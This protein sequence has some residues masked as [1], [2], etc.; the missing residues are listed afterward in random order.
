ML[1]DVLERCARGITCCW[2]SRGGLEDV[3]KNGVLE[4]FIVSLSVSHL[5]G[6]FAV[7]LTLEFALVIHIFKWQSQ[8]EL[9]G[10]GVH[11]VYSFLFRV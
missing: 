11:W 9:F 3:C 1:K 4:A 2:T 7:Y 8:G 5:W 10:K 6:R